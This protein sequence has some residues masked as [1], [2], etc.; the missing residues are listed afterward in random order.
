MTASGGL[1]DD[2]HGDLNHGLVSGPLK[3]I[4]TSIGNQ[5][6]VRNAEQVQDTCR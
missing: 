5:D 4:Q 2:S 1:I 3:E 6:A